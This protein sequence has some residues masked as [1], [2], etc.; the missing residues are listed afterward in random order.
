MRQRVT[1][2]LAALLKPSIIIA[3]EPT[4]ELDVVVQ[5]RVVQLLQDLQQQLRN[6]IIL[7]THDMGVHANV[8]DR[9]A[10]MYAGKIIEEGTTAK[11][12]GDP[13][14]PYTR[15]LISSLPK[16]GDKATRTSAPGRPPSLIDLPSGCPFH[17]RCAEA[18]DICR[19]QMPAFTSLTANHRVACW[20]T[21]EGQ[22]EDG[23]T[24]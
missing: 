18:M 19:Q 15:Y 14:H 13:V 11:I 10:I 23:K 7:V 12:F 1:I 21:T 22:D 6:T 3:D 9:V 24:H 5:R 4:T 16:F 17:P 8:A 2:A 20:L